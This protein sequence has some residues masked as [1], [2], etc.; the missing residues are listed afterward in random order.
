MYM[1][2]ITLREHQILTEFGWWRY[3]I[4]DGQ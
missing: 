3:W 4:S 2:D 1:T